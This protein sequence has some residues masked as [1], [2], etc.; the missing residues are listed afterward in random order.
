VKAT[1]DDRGIPL[2]SAEFYDRRVELVLDGKPPYWVFNRDYIVVALNDVV[3]FAMV[4]EVMAEDTNGFI[5][6]G[7]VVTRVLLI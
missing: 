3:E 1:F 4:P 6:A 5:L 2:V 7:N